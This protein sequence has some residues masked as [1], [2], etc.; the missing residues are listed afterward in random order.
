MHTLAGQGPGVG[1]SQEDL[2]SGDGGD[3]GPAASAFLNRPQGVGIDESGHVFIADTNN[4]RIRELTLATAPVVP[5]V[6][7][8]PALALLGLV[9]AQLPRLA[10]RVPARIAAGL[11]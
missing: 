1:T 7:V 2:G 8:V 3:G 4:S 9:L 11:R 5:E 6:P 10:R